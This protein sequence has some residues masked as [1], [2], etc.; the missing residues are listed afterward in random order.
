MIN[1]LMITKAGNIVSTIIAVFMIQIGIDESVLGDLFD[2]LTSLGLL[3][4]GIFVL[5][6]QYRQSVT[7]N[8]RRDHEYMKMLERVTIALENSNKA[9]ENSN[10][11]VNKIMDKLQ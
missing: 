1:E 4:V 8:E 9:I 2:T 7:Y 6:K 3:G 11:T 5:W 10:A